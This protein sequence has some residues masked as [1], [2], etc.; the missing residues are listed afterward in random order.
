M[1]ALTHSLLDHIQ[2]LSTV[3]ALIWVDKSPVKLPSTRTGDSA[4]HPGLVR[5]PGEHHPMSLLPP[6][7][8]WWQG[9]PDSRDSITG[10]FLPLQGAGAAFWAPWTLCSPL[11]MCLV[12]RPTICL[13]VWNMH[14]SG[15]QTLVRECCAFAER[16]FF[17]TLHPKWKK[18]LTCFNPRKCLPALKRMIAFTFRASETDFF[19]IFQQLREFLKATRK[20]VPFLGHICLALPAVLACNIYFQVQIKLL[21]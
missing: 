17:P 14:K 8:C 20:W 4:R 15:Y 18:I 9:S 6:T 16:P 10:R 12:H 5:R 11:L 3:A 13:A 21:P 7:W 2:L 1:E 19:L